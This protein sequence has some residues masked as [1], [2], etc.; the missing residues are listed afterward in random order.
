MSFG[1]EDPNLLIETFHACNRRTGDG[2]TKRKYSA[3]PLRGALSFETTLGPVKNHQDL[4]LRLIYKKM[5]N[6][7]NI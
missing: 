7:K 6:E 3:T 5:R 4:H 1:S 2:K